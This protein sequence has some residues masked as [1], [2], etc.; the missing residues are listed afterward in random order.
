[1]PQ[2]TVTAKLLATVLATAATTRLGPPA[3]T[4]LTVRS[5]QPAE[6][7]MALSVSVVNTL[8]ALHSLVV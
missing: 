3:I 6:S 1:M 7:H 8:H 4:E 5:E 2:N